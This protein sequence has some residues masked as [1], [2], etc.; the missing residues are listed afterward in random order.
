MVECLDWIHLALYRE[1]WQGR[2]NTVVKYVIIEN[3]KATD[4]KMAVF[5]HD[6]R[7]DEDS[8]LL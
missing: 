5:W 2:V 4:K 6:Y 3:L 8:K 1:W 7:G